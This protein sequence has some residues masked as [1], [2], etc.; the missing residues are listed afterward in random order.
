MITTY[1]LKQKLIAILNEI[2]RKSPEEIKSKIN[3]SNPNLLKD[4]E[5][6]YENSLNMY[7]CEKI[8]QFFSEVNN[9]K[10]DVDFI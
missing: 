2:E 10:Q 6:I 1:S 5:S 9:A 7:L 3:F 4:I 8:E